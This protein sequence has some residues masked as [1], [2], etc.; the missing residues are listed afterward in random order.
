MPNE[1]ENGENNIGTDRA[2]KNLY[3]Q[4]VEWV[5]H[6]HLNSWITSVLSRLKAGGMGVAY[7]YKLS[8]VNSREL[9]QIWFMSMTVTSLNQRT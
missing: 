3:I 4:Q 9:T 8:P 7:I 6:K 2:L 1:T 5:E